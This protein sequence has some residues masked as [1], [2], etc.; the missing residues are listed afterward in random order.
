MR[1]GKTAVGHAP[2]TV[3]NKNLAYAVKANKRGGYATWV[4][5]SEIW[6][7]VEDTAKNDCKS[8]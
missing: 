2:G 8:A 1:V 5:R 7:V 3:A 6:Y 4:E